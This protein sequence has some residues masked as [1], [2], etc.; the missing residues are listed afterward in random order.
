MII[1]IK[2]RKFTKKKLRPSNEVTEDDLN[3]FL[4]RIKKVNGYPKVRDLQK[5]LR[6]TLNLV[7]INAILRYLEKSKR[8]EID[9]DGNIIWIREEQN[10]TNHYLSLAEVANVS[11]EFLEYFSTNSLDTKNES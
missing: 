3:F 8:L 9:L 6:P 1:C 11:Q 10:L 2:S 7:K 5:L 4:T